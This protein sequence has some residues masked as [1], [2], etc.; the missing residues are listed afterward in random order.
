M[1]AFT[2]GRER[3]RPGR[4]EAV[5]AEPPH[6]RARAPFPAEIDAPAIA[7]LAEPAARGARAELAAEVGPEACALAEV[8]LGGAL[9]GGTCRVLASHLLL[10]GVGLASLPI[11]ARNLGP[12]GY[13]R[14][15]LFVT[16]LG[17]VSN[18][19]CARPVLVRRLASGDGSAAAGCAGLARANA[20]G[21][22][23]AG[24]ALGAF[25][26]GALPAL[27][28]ALA[29]GLHGESARVYARLAARGR[30]ARALAARNVAWI[31][32]TLAAVALSFTRFEGAYVWAFAAANAGLLG[33]YFALA[34]GAEP[35]GAARGPR[36]RELRGEVWPE[37][38]ADVAGVLGFS[39]AAG[40]LVSADRIALEQTAEADVSG[41][42]IAHSDLAIKINAVGTA[43]GSILYPLFA[44]EIASRGERE[45]SRRFVHVA[46]W[47]AGA[48][49]AV[50]LL[51]LCAE[52]H[53]VR[54]CLGSSYA[55]HHW[56]YA[57]SLIGV[58]VHLWG[59]LLTPWQRA[60]GEF[61][62]QRRT[63]QGAALAVLAACFVLVPR[64]GAAGALG[65]Y[66]LAR[67]A[68]LALFVRE[69]RRMPADVLSGRRLAALGLMLAVLVA[70]ALESGFSAPG[71]LAA[72]GLDG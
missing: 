59:F 12:A 15:S 62:S 34:G 28:L 69:A 41:A 50:I 29:V 63:Y 30:V 68:E 72:G 32:A 2:G 56:I 21:L 67:S 9:L 16:L 40:L 35:S 33:T 4:A 51:L 46:S 52:R 24:A 37:H 6:E 1:R 8:S 14:F 39:A 48:Y 47:I 27:A 11:L 36:W 26:L 43:L 58:F 65:V 70:A 22:A 3:P 13:G 18:L 25:A 53:V 66:F 44:R 42:Y 20:L 7:T 19:D 60:R 38:R 61:H 54:W 57:L 64:F 17:V 23:L 10:A 71:G 5:L 55:E 45:A 49:F 31:G